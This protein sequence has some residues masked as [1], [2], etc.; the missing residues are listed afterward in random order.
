MITTGEKQ[1]NVLLEFYSP[2]CGGC[3]AFAP[4]LNRIANYLSTNIPNRKVVRFDITE[5]D[6][7]QIDGKDVFE[8]KT[9]PTL[10]RVRYSPSFLVEFYTGDHDFDSIIDW[11]S[12]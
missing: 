2:Y 1:E 8:V 7:P 3:Q 12:K 9:T 5:D 10:Y 4:T 6:I 11:F